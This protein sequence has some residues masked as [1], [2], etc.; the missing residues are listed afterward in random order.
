VLTNKIY[1][2]ISDTRIWILDYNFACALIFIPLTAYA[3]FKIRKIRSAK[4]LKQDRKLKELEKIKEIE[5]L[6]RILKIAGLGLSVPG[7]VFLEILHL[8]GGS[9][10]VIP[11]IDD[12]KKLFA[13]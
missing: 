8:R 2:K 4:K 12:C 6:Y 5:R 1:I 9:S 10:V 3:S 11:D 13:I 7:L